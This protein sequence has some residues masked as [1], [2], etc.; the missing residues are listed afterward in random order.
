MCKYSVLAESCPV[1]GSVEG[2]PTDFI[3]DLSYVDK[4]ATQI[5]DKSLGPF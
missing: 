4:V 3:K 1:R 5:E 2:M